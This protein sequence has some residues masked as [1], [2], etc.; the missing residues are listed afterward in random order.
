MLTASDIA[1][2]L[3]VFKE[4]ELGDLMALSS[5]LVPRELAAGDIF[6]HEGSTSQRIGYINKGLI[7]A[8][9]LKANGQ[10][11]TMFLSWEGQFVASPDG[12]FLQRPA[13]YTYQ[14]L[15]DTSLIEMDYGR[16][17]GVI[18]GNPR[19]S[20]IRNGVLMQML[21]QAVTRVEGFVLLSPEERYKKL[22]REKQDII[23]R[24]ADKH[25]ATLL[26]I[27]A[28][29]LSRIRRRMAKTAKKR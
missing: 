8:Y 6:I 15:E 7:R 10:E 20:M 9:G 21:A 24:V 3:T 16:V 18:D 19:L 5:L 17:S 29:S 1:P 27:T 14:A 12:I 4:L 2:Y 22:V 23:N 25:L 13:A 11:A 26:G 28:I